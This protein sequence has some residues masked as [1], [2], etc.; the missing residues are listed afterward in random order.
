MFVLSSH[1]IIGD[2]VFDFVN[3]VEINSS[4][5]TLTDTATVTLPANVKVLKKGKKEPLNALKISE[6]IKIGD[7][8][9]IA[10]GYDE[11]LS[12]IFKGYVTKLTTKIPIE[13]ECEDEM[14]QLK[15]SNI[16]DSGRKASLSDIMAK[17]FN[18]YETNILDVDLGKYSIDNLSQ[19]QLLEQLKKDFGLHSFFRK[20]V[21]NVGTIHDVNIA[22]TV[23]FTL[24]HNV[25]SEDLEYTKA[26]DMRIAV[27]AISNNE[28]GT[29][30][31]IE[32]GDKDGETRTLNFYNLSEKELKATAQR[33]MERLKYDGW[34]G[35]FTA[36]GLPLVRQ[37]DIIELKTEK[38]SDKQ[39]KYWCDAVTY[40][41]GLNG[42][43]Q[44]I[45]LGAKL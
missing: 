33:E 35:S 44:V 13:I 19:A 23:S 40:E 3:S 36:F 37:G 16:I 39:G 42:F 14:F 28:N 12:T 24:N 38:D 20:D 31:T 29:K 27:K 1:I 32:L 21:L 11:N 6:Y 17:Y 22:N 2:L 7:V 4:W 9:T 26:E 8:V 25:V 43:R 5:N 41:F 30:T 45:T 15:Q 18:K 34:R 10:L